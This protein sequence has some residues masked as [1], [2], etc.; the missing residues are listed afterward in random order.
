MQRVMIIW[1]GGG[2]KT[3]LALRMAKSTGLPL[4]EIDSIQFQ[5][6]WVLSPINQTT[7]TLNDIQSGDPWIIDGFGP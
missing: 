4:T 7:K 2:G 3:T 1:N 6:G 5:P